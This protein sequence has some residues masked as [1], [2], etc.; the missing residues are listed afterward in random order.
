MSTTHTLAMVTLGFAPSTQSLEAQ[1]RTRY[2]DFQLG[3]DL[4][5][6][7]VLAKVAATD[8]K[9]IHQRPAVM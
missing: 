3:S 6:V 9:T 7:S 1:D 4:Q 8:A 2:R 5:S